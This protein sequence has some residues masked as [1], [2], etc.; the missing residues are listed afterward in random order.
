MTGGG[1]SRPVKPYFTCFAYGPLTDFYFARL[2]RHLDLAVVE[3]LR[4]QGVPV[5]DIYLGDSLSL[6]DEVT[7]FGFGQAMARA[8]AARVGGAYGG[9]GGLG[10]AHAG[11]VC[12]GA[13]GAIWSRNGGGFTKTRTSY[14]ARTSS[15]GTRSTTTSSSFISEAG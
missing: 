2:E 9:C 13:G 4:G 5:T 1:G 11:D 10:G 3:F 14:L 15:T 6:F 12:G 8:L 7:P